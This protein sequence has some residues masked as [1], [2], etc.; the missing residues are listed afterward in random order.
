MIHFI[1]AVHIKIAFY[2]ERYFQYWWGDMIVLKD[3]RAGLL[4]P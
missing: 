2:S 1:N 3:T 4:P